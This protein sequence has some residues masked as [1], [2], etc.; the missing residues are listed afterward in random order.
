[1]NFPA[2]SSL[3]NNRAKKS[4]MEGQRFHFFLSPMK[5][6]EEC[7]NNFIDE[8]R[9]FIPELEKNLYEQSLHNLLLGVQTHKTQMQRNLQQGHLKNLGFLISIFNDPRFDLLNLPRNLYDEF[10]VS[11]SFE[12]HQKAFTL[13]L[14]DGSQ[15]KTFQYTPKS[16][17]LIRCLETG[18][19]S[20]ELLELFKTY[21]K[22]QWADGSII[23]RITDYRFDPPRSYAYPL[24]IGADIIL[25]YGEREMS[26]EA[27]LEVQRNI[28][29]TANPDLALDPSPDVSRINSVLD[30]RIKMWDS[31]PDR[32]ETFPNTLQPPTQSQ[33]SSAPKKPINTIKLKKSTQPLYFPQAIYTIFSNSLPPPQK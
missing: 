1:M 25:S 29:L 14:A 32:R 7:Q 27:H 17:E 15:T 2:K 21:G 16:R 28:L 4:K 11:F 18:R 10:N 5:D 30:E 26:E 33:Q 19:I 31:G 13:S 20:Q 24:T 23:V 12:F 9:Q 3:Q 6:D 22:I 8:N